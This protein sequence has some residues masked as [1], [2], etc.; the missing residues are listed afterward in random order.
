MLAFITTSGNVMANV[1][2]RLP[3]TWFFAGGSETCVSGL[4]FYGGSPACR[5]LLLWL[6]FAVMQT[7]AAPLSVWRSLWQQPWLLH[8]VACAM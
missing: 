6:A 1:Q 8:H 2:H 4:A 7:V 3:R 5:I